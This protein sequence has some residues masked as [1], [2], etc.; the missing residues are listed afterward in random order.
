MNESATLDDRG[1]TSVR[2]VT[3]WRTAV[4]S[5]HVIF[6]QARPEYRDWYELCASGGAR[7]A[8]VRAA[9]R[10]DADLRGG[11]FARLDRLLDRIDVSQVSSTLALGLV[12][13]TKL[14]EHELASRGSLLAR[15]HEKLA[16]EL[17]EVR[18]EALLLPA[19]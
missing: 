17:G 19:R 8:A 1:T 10:V 9:K 7:E 4:V 14:A 2:T 12:A 11:Q 13:W 18:A 15:V 6:T 5:G 16:A 3:R